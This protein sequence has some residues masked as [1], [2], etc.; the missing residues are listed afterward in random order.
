MKRINQVDKK[1]DQ[2][3]DT[4]E[5]HELLDLKLDSNVYY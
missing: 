2:K 5:A 4:E 1:F 3:I